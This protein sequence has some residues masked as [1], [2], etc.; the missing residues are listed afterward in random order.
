M[1]TFQEKESKK[2]RR[3][4]KLKSAFIMRGQTF[5]SVSIRLN[6]SRSAITKVATGQSRSRR[7]EAA[8]AATAGIPL[9]ELWK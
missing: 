1:S 6:V 7:I 9:E 4:L 8:L 3:Y 2:R 5:L